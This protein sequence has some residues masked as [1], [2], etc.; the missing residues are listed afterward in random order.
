MDDYTTDSRG[1]RIPGLRKLV[2]NETTYYT[3][4][5]KK[6]ENR[7][8]W[9]KPNEKRLMSFIPGTVRDICVKAGQEVSAG[10]KLLVLEAMKMMNTI[11]APFDGKV[12]TVQVADGDRIPKGT[13]I[14]EFE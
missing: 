4:F 1:E 9:E 2:V 3:T 11:Y 5:T 13:L 12:K 7:P 6:Y 10:D 8:K 14:V